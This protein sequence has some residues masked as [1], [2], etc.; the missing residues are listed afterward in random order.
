LAAGFVCVLGFPLSNATV[1]RGEIPFPTFS[2]SIRDGQAA[3]VV[4]YDDNRRIR[5]DKGAL[6]ILGGRG[7]DWGDGGYGWLPYA[8]V[9]QR[10]AVDLWTVMKRDWLRS[11]EFLSPC[12]Q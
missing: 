12:V 4:G 1:E 11:G 5:S 9:R 3:A 8:F 2:D 6:S 7:P 10:L